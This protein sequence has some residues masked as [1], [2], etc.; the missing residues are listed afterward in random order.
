M[1]IS[2]SGASAPALVTDG[3][4][5]PRPRQVVGSSPTAAIRGPHGYRNH[6]LTLTDLAAGPHSPTAQLP[7]EK[8]N[9]R[10]HF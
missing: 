7:E 6:Y 2:G 3:G 10:T 8:K 9:G 1:G 5:P 4:D